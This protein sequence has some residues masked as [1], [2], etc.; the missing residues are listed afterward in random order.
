MATTNTTTPIDKIR[1]KYKT[2]IINLLTKNNI[3]YAKRKGNYIEN[4]IYDK[5]PL[6]DNL[7]IELS[8]Y[9]RKLI[10]IYSNLD[11][12]SYIQNNYLIEKLQKN[13]IDYKNLHKLSSKKLF[14]NRWK[15]VNNIILKKKI[16]GTVTTQFTC[17]ECKKNNCS[18]YQAQTRSMDEGMC[19]FVSCLECG[20]RWKT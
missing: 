11:P 14:P 1:T 4:S 12:N 5:Y 15:T 19:T 20:N 18:Y 7:K 16:M 2:I 3:K 17:F 10:Q 13:E 6:K 8:L 9:F